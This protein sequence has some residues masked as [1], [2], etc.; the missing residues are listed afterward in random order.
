MQSKKYKLL[1]LSAALSFPYLLFCIFPTL[2]SFL[3][4]ICVRLT[5]FLPISVLIHQLFHLGPTETGR[6]RERIKE[7]QKRP[8]QRG[9]L[10]S[11]TSPILPLLA[12]CH[13]NLA[14]RGLFHLVFCVFKESSC[15]MLP[16]DADHQRAARCY[17][18]HYTT[19]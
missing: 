19:L 14:S 13:T 18:Q 7:G 1:K 16:A 12:T 2:S 9:G 6:E 17:S 10:P 5:Q 8:G 4:F 15:K 3:V 11:W